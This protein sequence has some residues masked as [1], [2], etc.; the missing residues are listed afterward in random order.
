MSHA[1]GE[2]YSGWPS[3]CDP[4]PLNQQIQH[5]GKCHVN[6]LAGSFEVTPLPALR[7]I[8]ESPEQDMRAIEMVHS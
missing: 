5:A 1:K 7:A 4:G 6:P 3:K 8:G 2:V